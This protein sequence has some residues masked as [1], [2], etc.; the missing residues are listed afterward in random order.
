V[1]LG[2]RQ[3]TG[4]RRAD[5]EIVAARR[6][7]GYDSVRD[8]W[9]RTGLEREALERLAAAD[10]FRS[11]GLDRREAAWAV[12]A[13]RRS[14]DKDD[15]PL[16]RDAGS[17]AEPDARLPAMPLG[18]HV[19]HDY[20]KLSLSL[21]AHPAA[22]ARAALD[23]RGARRAEDL[24]RLPPGR[25]VL[26]AG[27]VLVRQRPG[28]AKG[29]IFMTLEDE[30]GVANII[31]WPKVFEA[32][33]PLVLGSRF[34]LVRGRLQNEKGVVHVVANRIEDATPLLG[35]MTREE[36]GEGPALAGRAALAPADHVRRP[37]PDREG[38]RLSPAKREAIARLL[39][40]EPDLAAD[41]TV[42]ARADE[43]RRPQRDHR[44]R[45]G[46][47]AEPAG[48][49]LAGLTGVLP[50]GRNFQ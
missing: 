43:V 9:L 37:L 1:R 12:K 10:A 49:G 28:S 4:M 40:E 27:L 41:L 20:R 42:L 19:V 44:D 29:V 33:R 46:A 3:I 24:A 23:R 26:V 7:A 2:L 22:F 50:K 25:E 30:S 31:I 5:A 39:A 32:Y 15:L 14:G 36:A 35:A 45:R 47:P 48:R 34:A 18:E 11:L 17:E 6:G 21:K 13:L 16:F 38:R 8:L